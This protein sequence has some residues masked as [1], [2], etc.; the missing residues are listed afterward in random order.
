MNKTEEKLVEARKKIKEQISNLEL[1]MEVIQDNLKDTKST[2]RELKEIFNKIEE[3]L[4]EF[5]K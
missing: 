2:I 4:K 3:K 1:K 5:K